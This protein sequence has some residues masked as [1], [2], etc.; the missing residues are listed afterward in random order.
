MNRALF[1]PVLIIASTLT[2]HSREL[3]VLDVRGYE[4]S[5]QDAR[6]HK[7]PGARRALIGLLGPAF[8]ASIAYVDP[9]NV[10]AN[11][12][13]GAQYGYLLVWV[14]VAAN[15]MAVAT[16]MIPLLMP[17]KDI[18]RAEAAPMGPSRM[19]MSRP[20]SVSTETWPAFGPE[21]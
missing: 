4:Q 18:L 3:A 14:L 12:T 20:C 1:R 10:A 11:L 7:R 13:A 16:A 15:V 21:A 17:A 5:P 6:T 2:R 19:R 9:G 8:V